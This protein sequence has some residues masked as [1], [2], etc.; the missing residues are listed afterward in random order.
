MNKRK[1]KV[2]T[3]NLDLKRIERKAY[4][5]T[6]MNGSLESSGGQTLEELERAFS[7]FDDYFPTKMVLAFYDVLEALG[8][9]ETCAQN[10]EGESQDNR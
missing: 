9:G 1:A 8:S 6:V 10:D 5:D 2:V 3:F 4:N 7:A